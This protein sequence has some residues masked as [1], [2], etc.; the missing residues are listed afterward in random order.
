[1]LGCLGFWN[2]K[3]NKG[4]RDPF[5]YRARK[6]YKIRNLNNYGADHNY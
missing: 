4:I 1:M 5:N 3:N 6:P 2:F